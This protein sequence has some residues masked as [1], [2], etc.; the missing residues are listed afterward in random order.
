MLALDQGGDPGLF[1]PES[2]VNSKLVKFLEKA[3][4]QGTGMMLAHVAP[5][6]PAPP[7]PAAPAKSGVP[8]HFGNGRRWVLASASRPSTS[9]P[10][11]I[12]SST[13]TKASCSS[14]RIVSAAIFARSY[15]EASASI[16][17][18]FSSALGGVRP[19]LISNQTVN[20]VSKSRA[21]RNGNLN[22]LPPT[23]VLLMMQMNPKQLERQEFLT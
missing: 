13:S 21:S 5:F 3:A 14:R 8:I 23:L 17:C 2:S 19:I 1:Y 10:C 20:L 16:L 7:T 22:I 4:F 18:F 9:T 15:N 11:T 6:T 12:P